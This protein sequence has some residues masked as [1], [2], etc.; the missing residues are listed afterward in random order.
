M[1]FQHLRGQLPHPA[2]LR[3]AARQHHA[4]AAGAAKSRGL[5]AVLHH[6]ENF[7][8]PRPDHADEKAARNFRNLMLILAHLRHRQQFTLIIRA[9]LH[10]AIQRLQPFGMRN[11]G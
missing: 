10:V 1:A 5:Q 2:Q 6:L 4:I 7:F 8:N 3:S 11:R 9:A